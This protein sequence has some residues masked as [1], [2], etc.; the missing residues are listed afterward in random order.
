[1]PAA[2][3]PGTPSRAL[4]GRVETGVVESRIVA[5][6]VVESRIVVAAEQTVISAAP[7]GTRLRALGVAPGEILT[8]ARRDQ[9]GELR[10]V[11]LATVASRSGR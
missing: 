10:F 9:P 8:V 5:T 11:E 2:V 7:P 4:D 3:P 6:G 1:V